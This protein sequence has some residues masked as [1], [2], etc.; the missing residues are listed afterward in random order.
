MRRDRAKTREISP[1]HRYK[2]VRVA[3]FINCLMWQGKKSVA[4]SVFYGALDRLEEKGET[5][6]EVFWSALEGVRPLM[7]VRS[8]RVGGAT[9]Q[10][11]MEMSRE[12]SD[13]FSRR[14]IIHAAR[15]RNERTMIER[16][17]G[18]LL[19]AS[20]QKGEAFKKKENTHR[21][22]EANRAYAHYR[23]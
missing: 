9:Y 8:R 7:E 6:L 21:M 1:D 22:A 4:Q 13:Q 19:D 11:P 14:W 5:P 18:E 16:L 23:W 20:R 17:S 3:K 2:D 15:N 10:V 12:R